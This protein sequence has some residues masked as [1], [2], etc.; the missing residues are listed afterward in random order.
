MRRLAPD[1]VIFDMALPDRD[2]LEGVRAL[3]SGAPRPIVMFSDKDDPAFV[4]DAIAAGVCSYNL[5]GVSDRDMKAIVASA[6][7]LFQ[8]YTRVE[9]E[10]A[11][12]TAQLEERR[13]I[14]CAKAL[15]MAERKVTE[16]QA[17][18]WLRNKAMN[19]N[20]RIA[21]V[22]A[23]LIKDQDTDGLLRTVTN[24][25]RRTSRQRAF[26][27]PPRE[28]LPDWRQICEVAKR[29]GFGDAFSYRSPAE[30]FAEYA[31]LTGSENDGRRDL[32]LGALADISED[33]YAVLAPF[34]W[35]RRAGSSPAEM[36]FF[37]DGRFY[38]ADGKA[39]FVVTPFRA[40]A[41]RT[42]EQFPFVL[43]TG[44]I[45]DQWHTMTRTAKTPRLMAHIGE[46]FV[47]VHPD[48]AKTIGVAAADLAEIESEQSR[49]DARGRQ[50]TAAARL[51]VCPDALDRSICRARASRRA[52][53]LRGRSG[54]RPAGAQIHH[55][56]RT[57]L[58]RRLA[59]LRRVARADRNRRR[60]LLRNRAR[61]RR[62]EGR[63]GGARSAR[64]LDGVRASYA[65]TGRRSR[66][67]R[68]SRRWGRS[69][70][71]RRVRQR[72]LRWSNLHRA[73]AGHGG[74]LLDH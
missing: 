39:R 22:A 26:L 23:D 7:A 49:R 19:D 6:V 1:L 62:M 59:R 14:E 35:P 24:S 55:G 72:D 30:I 32:D 54:L 63:T 61:A 21:Q 33:D 3:S 56:R 27:A 13:V 10:L 20:R 47:E 60:R 48:D 12:A 69:A 58:Y 50:R 52:R 18:R 31:R 28:A 74:S 36:R 17:Y 40:Q 8:R 34:Q 16:P 42:S 11:A 15:L 65:R 38:H 5:S 43:N 46:P 2:A 25:E 37:A 53:L 70:P 66:N 71:F 67:D 57:A 64:R 29:M 73:W 45:R 51:A 68:L 9:T 44:R 41:S 4:G